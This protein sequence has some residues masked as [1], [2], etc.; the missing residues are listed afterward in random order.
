MT[1][2]SIL[3]LPFLISACSGGAS[4]ACKVF[5]SDAVGKVY[6]SK[7][8]AAELVGVQRMQD[9]TRSTCD[10]DF[11]DGQWLSVTVTERKTAFT[12]EEISTFSGRN[13]ELSSKF[14]YPVI[15]ASGSKELTAFVAPTRE[16][17]LRTGANAGQGYST[18][19]VDNVDAKLSQ[20][21]S[22]IAL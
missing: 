6:D 11:D 14:G 15:H 8:K 13:S 21:L 2:V 10:V 3:V 17:Y 12:D 19:M 9:E 4:D 5:S 16:V 22:K 20:T 7:V 18:S 1:R